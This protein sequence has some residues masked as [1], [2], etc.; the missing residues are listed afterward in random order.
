MLRLGARPGLQWI[1]AVHPAGDRLERLLRGFQLAGRDRQ[2]TVDRQ[3]E[4]LL[5]P[6]LLLEPLAPEPERRP[7]AR[8]HVGLEGFDV[9]ADR[10]RGFGLSV[11]EIGEQV[12]VVDARERARQ[13]VVDEFLRAAEGL[14]ADFDENAR[15]ILDVVA[16]GLDEARNLAQLREDAARPIRCRRMR[17]E[18]LT[19]Q[20]RRDDVSIKL[21]VLLPGPHLL[22]LE[23]PRADVAGEHAT[24]EP[25]DVG[26]P[27]GHG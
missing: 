23:H 17:E 7:R 21:R 26:Q 6:H 10:V 14:D 24:L 9:G 3:R 25:L 22:E 27:L 16:R 12:H 13:I 15:R 19:R 11:R 1:A 8:R 2:Q 20:T 18:R 4:S 5:E